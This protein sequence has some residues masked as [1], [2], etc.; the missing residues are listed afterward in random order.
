MAVKVIDDGFLDAAAHPD[1]PEDGGPNTV[2]RL[3]KS[4][5]RRL[6]GFLTHKLHNDDD[7]QDASQEVFLKLWKQEKRGQLR[8]EASAYMF[9]AARSVA[10]DCERRRQSHRADQML[11]LQDGELAEFP[12]SQL[13][14]ADDVQHWRQAIAALVSILGDLPE[15]TQRVFMLYHLENLNYA[16]IAR[17]LG[18]SE[19]SVERHMARAFSHCRERLERF[20]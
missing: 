4:Q 8:A 14:P 18:M 3:F 12:D 7:A 2:V 11:D 17:R 13:A 20:L 10:V 15:K 6:V 16:D 19:R 1:S 5:S 9:S